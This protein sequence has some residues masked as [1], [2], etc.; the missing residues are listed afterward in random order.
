MNTEEIPYFSG[1]QNSF[2]TDNKELNSDGERKFKI[3]NVEELEEE[4]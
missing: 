2:S 1:L 4:H 3:E